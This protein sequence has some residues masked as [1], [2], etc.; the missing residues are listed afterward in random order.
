MSIMSI[1]N[2]CVKYGK[3]IVL[4]E[5]NAEINKGDIIALIGASGSGKTALL[6][7][8]NY[9]DPPDSGEIIFMGK[10]IEMKSIIQTRRKIGMVFK[11]SRLFRHLTLQENIALGPI[12]YQNISKEQA[13]IKSM[14][15]LKSVG[16]AEKANLYPHQMYERQRLRVALARCIA[17]NPDIL[18]I[19]DSPGMLEQVAVDGIMSYVENYTQNKL[20]L[21]IETYNVDFL[22]NTANRIFYIDEQ[23]IYE[24]GNPDMI[25][26]S[27]QKEKTRDYITK[28]HSI[29]YEIQ[30]RDFDFID[31]YNSLEN[32][33]IRN[34]IEITTAAKLYLLVDEI[35]NNVIVPIYEACSMKISYSKRA[36]TFEIA[37]SYK[38]ESINV[39]ESTDNIISMKMI[40]KY[41]NQI[42][43][44]FVDGV[45]TLYF[46]I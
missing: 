13:K 40:K 15:L 8:I 31:L 12:K 32:F 36:N 6:R 42:R 39:I 10:P 2:L 19:D 3:N 45:N 1:N 11:D 4:Q 16:L 35:I 44:E 5:V 18:L 28:L 38:G 22:R 17:M 21:L 23:K 34:Y 20:T 41:S 30:S 46:E 7:A 29:S 37:V 27:P 26:N 24:E 9:L 43:H 25:F 33:C 14:Q